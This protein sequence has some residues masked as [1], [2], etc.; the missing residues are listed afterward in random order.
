MGIKCGDVRT[1]HRLES[2]QMRLFIGFHSVSLAVLCLY[3]QPC[4][5]V[6]ARRMGV[7]CRRS[8][9][10]IHRS[11][12]APPSSF[13]SA[14]RQ[15]GNRVLNQH[16]HAPC[17]PRDDDIYRN[18]RVLFDMSHQVVMKFSLECRGSLFRWLLEPP[19]WRLIFQQFS[20]PILHHPHLSPRHFPTNRRLLGPSFLI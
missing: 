9:L 17:V 11:H 3:F 16:L 13:S 20:F 6:P 1:W 7:A 5:R 12:R 2:K 8:R 19:G 18:L 14:Q 15:G 10:S 4:T